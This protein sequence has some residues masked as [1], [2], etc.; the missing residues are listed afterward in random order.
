M[1]NPFR[2]RGTFTVLLVTVALTA[3]AQGLFK[4]PV[5]EKIHYSSLIVEGRVMSQEGFWNEQHT[6][7]FTLN[8]F[9]GI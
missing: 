7:I 2:L 8:K 5:E 1:N 6:M 3:R 4:I 9:R